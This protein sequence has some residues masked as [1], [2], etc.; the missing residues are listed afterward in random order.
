[1][2]SGDGDSAAHRLGHPG[3]APSAGPLAAPRP[4]AGVPDGSGRAAFRVC[5]CARKGG[6]GL[7]ATVGA[8][9]RRPAPRPTRRRSGTWRPRADESSWSAR[10]G[11]SEH[12]VL[13]VQEMRELPVD[14]G[15]ARRSVFRSLREVLGVAPQVRFYAY[16][17]GRARRRRAVLGAFR[18]RLGSGRQPPPG[19][20]ARVHDERIGAAR[21]RR[22]VSPSRW[23]SLRKIRI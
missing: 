22:P 3:V 21:Q 13:D 4:H 12:W 18:R 15:H 20:L 6:V 5:W 1:M 17:G 14:R 11:V 9:G 16:P 8:A 10:T 2:G 7:G 19:H 23:T